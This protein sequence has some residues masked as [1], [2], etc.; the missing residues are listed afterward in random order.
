[1]KPLSSY[2]GTWL[3]LPSEFEKWLAHS[4][5]R[6]GRGDL[7]KLGGRSSRELPLRLS[8]PRWSDLTMKES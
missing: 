6:I 4:S 7:P 3:L 5:I 1:M 8:L 2:L